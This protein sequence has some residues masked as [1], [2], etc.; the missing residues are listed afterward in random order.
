MSG[1]VWDVVV[2]GLGGLGSA[3]ARTLAT[4][5]LRVLGLDQFPAGHVRGASHGDSRIVRVSYHTPAYVRNAVESLADWAAVEAGTGERLVTRCG[6]LDLFPEGAA[7]DIDTYTASLT[8]TGIG[9]EVLDAAAVMRRWPAFRLEAGTVGLFQDRS[10]LVAAGRAVAVLQASATGHGADL[11]FGVRVRELDAG[12]GERVRVVTDD[13]VVHVAGAVVV[14]ADAWTN[15]VLAGLGARLPLTVTREQALHY[16]VA[17][18][19]AHAPNVMP[20][21]IWMDDPSFYG[22]PTVDGATVKVGEDCGGPVTDPD[23]ALTDGD[24]GMIGRSEAF[25]HHL[26]PGTGPVAQVTRCLYTLTPDRDFVADRVPGHDNVVVG[27]GAGHG[28]KFAAWFGRVLADLATT[29]ATSSDIS[30]FALDRP[31][32]AAEGSRAA[33][34]V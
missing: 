27:L 4:R 31:S 13:G 30:A 28:F 2:I 7:I 16:R 22:F 9:F 1:D 33:W 11:R 14:A 15:D 34:L 20:V 26:L 8:A 23:I 21:W 25:T 10:G 3:T 32:L 24:P 12:S 6:G 5:G 18:P 29:G 19:A 17:D